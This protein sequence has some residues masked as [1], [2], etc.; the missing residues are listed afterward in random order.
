MNK[1]I[2]KAVSKA[3][4]ILSTKV[5]RKTFLKTL[6]AGGA[7]L[8][9]SSNT[10]KKVFAQNTKSI[11]PRKRRAGVVT[12]YDLTAVTGDDIEMI[13]RKCVDLLGGMGKFVK[14]GDTVVVKP[15][16]GWNRAP[17]YAANTNPL[18]VSA[19]VKMCFENGAKT[20]KI[21]DNTCNDRKLCYE[22][23][24]I[25]K[26]AKD[27]GA[28]VFYMDDWKYAP[29][30]FMKADALMQ[31][32]PIFRDAV[33][34]DSFINV[35]IAKQHGSGTLTLSVKNLMGVCGGNR[36][37]MHWEM[38]K[39]L[40]ELIGFIEPDLNIIDAYNILTANGPRGGNL[41]DVAR[42]NTIIAST[43]PVLADSYA[44]ETLFNIKGSSIPHI[45]RSAEYGAGNLFSDKAKTKIEKI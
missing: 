45:R 7:V 29:A 25:M 3:K 24:G 23:S 38:D 19:V 21:F 27:A 32:W 41:K 18:V 26:A 17:E 10:A 43:D 42:K 35:P 4:K 28:T 20:V 8:A 36:G 33:E 30:K 14:N 16:I 12:D 44:S 13:T 31:D 5:N 9:F 15:N 2:E 6:A 39:K 22:N 1:K 34:C 40:A 37:Q 11:S